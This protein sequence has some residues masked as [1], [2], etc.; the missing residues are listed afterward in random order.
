MKHERENK[1]HH[2]EQRGRYWILRSVALQDDRKGTPSPIGLQMFQ[3]LTSSNSPFR[4]SSK[5]IQ[6]FLGRQTNL[7]IRIRLTKGLPT[8]HTTWGFEFSIET[9]FLLMTIGTKLR[10]DRIGEKLEHHQLFSLFLITGYSLDYPLWSNYERTN[11]CYLSNEEICNFVLLYE[12]PVHPLLAA[13]MPSPGTAAWYPHHSAE[14][15]TG[16]RP[17]IK[18][19]LQTEKLLE[20]TQSTSET[21]RFVLRYIAHNED[22]ELLK[23]YL[24]VFG[25]GIEENVSELLEFECPKVMDFLWG[26]K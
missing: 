20:M 24:E 13:F 6:D 23:L 12:Y 14:F 25:D 11:H 21:R 16:Y 22:L 8:G 17:L 10:D 5:E 4:Y 9:T 19:W 7:D 2:D 3:D 1:E 26:G 18:V 15:Y